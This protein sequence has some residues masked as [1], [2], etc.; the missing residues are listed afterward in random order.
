MSI[1]LTTNKLV[2]ALKAA[3]QDFEFYPP[4]QEIINDLRH[5][6]IKVKDRSYRSRR[7]TESMLDIGAGNGKVLKAVAGADTGITELFAIEKSII[8]CQQLDPSILIVGTDFAQQTLFSK[9]VDI[10]FCNPP[11]S[12]FEEWCDKIIRQSACSWIYLVIPKRWEQSF[13]IADAIRW[14]GVEIKVI[15]DYD[16][17]DAEDR[18]ARA[19]VQL[20]LLELPE[21]DNAFDRFFEQEFAGLYDKFKENKAKKDDEESAPAKEEKFG[22]L[23]LGPSYPET[24]VALYDA[25]MAN[26]QNNYKLVSQLDVGLLKEFDMNPK[27]IMD[28]LKA[29]LKG[30]KLEY[31]AELFSRL[32]KITSRLTSKSRK[33]LL[34]TLN[35][36][37]EVDFTHGNIL[38][39]V[40]WV[41]NNANQYLES[42]LI[43]IYDVMVD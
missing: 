34:E 10:V 1:P 2:P 7:H 15:G 27:R 13:V 30:M 21:G 24:L 4:T 28:C 16:F 29:R 20:I 3:E 32:D 11:Y 41:I 12:Q 6:I 39:V 18:T 42:Q 23:V 33:G 14:R 26:V 9:Q 37:T 43:D 35:K 25:E 31:W 40:I 36:H 5:D 8:L 17:E 22:S 38:A 19:K